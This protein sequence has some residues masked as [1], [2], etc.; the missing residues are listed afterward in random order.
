M[1]LRRLTLYS[2]QSALK[3]RIPEQSPRYRDKTMTHEVY[4][5]H[6]AEAVGKTDACQRLSSSNDADRLRHNQRLQRASPETIHQEYVDTRQS[7]CRGEDEVVTPI[8]PKGVKEFV[9][10]RAMAGIDILAEEW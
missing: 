6:K 9:F 10:G 4:H 8:R 2:S 5:D 1:D 3:V 7:S